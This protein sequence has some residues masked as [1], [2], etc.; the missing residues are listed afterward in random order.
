MI[1]SYYEM[2]EEMT[3][4]GFGRKGLETYLTR[5]PGTFTVGFAEHRLRDDVEG[6]VMGN[7]GDATVKVGE[8][9]LAE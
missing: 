4:F 6:V 1:N 7:C 2:A 5:V 8:V 9:R 3:V